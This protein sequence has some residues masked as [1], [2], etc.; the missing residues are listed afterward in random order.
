M[1]NNTTRGLHQTKV[2]INPSTTAAGGTLGA[3]LQDH[4][5]YFGTFTANGVTP[6]TVVEPNI[7]ANCVVAICL[8][9]VGG[10]VGAAPTIQTITA[11]TGFTVAAT[12]SDTSVYAYS[13]NRFAN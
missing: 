13:V 3:T 12:A 11:G 5:V 10:T 7:T 9:T 6:V 1:V 2:N 8:K 4:E